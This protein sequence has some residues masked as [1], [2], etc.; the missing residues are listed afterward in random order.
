M[1]FRVIARLLNEQT[2]LRTELRNQMSQVI[3]SDKPKWKFD[4]PAD[5]SVDQ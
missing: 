3:R 5:R 1:T 4:D 2:F